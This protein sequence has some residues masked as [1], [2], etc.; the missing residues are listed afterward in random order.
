VEHYEQLRPLVLDRFQR[1]TGQA[2]KTA[3][4]GADDGES[5]GV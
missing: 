4:D 1:E 3:A 5:V 2:L